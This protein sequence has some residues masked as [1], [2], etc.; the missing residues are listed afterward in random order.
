MI[1]GLYAVVPRPRRPAR[2]RAAR[3]PAH[4]RRSPPALRGGGVEVVHDA[5]FDTLT[6]RVPGRRRRRS[7]AAARARRHQP[8]RGRRRHARHRARRDDDAR[9]S[10]TR[11]SARSASTVGRRR[12]GGDARSRPRSRARRSSSRT[13]CSRRTA[14]RPDAAL[15]APA[16]RP[17]PRARPHDDPARLVHDEAQRDRRDGADHVARVRAHPPVRAGR[18]GRRATSS[19]STTSSAGSREITGY[20]AVSLQPN[21]GSQGEFAGLLAIREYHASQRRRRGA[22]CA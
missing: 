14:P 6:V 2:D 5:F 21:A 12:R 13:R 18:P 1:A 22:T 4:A 20:D 19:C 11:C 17:R 16:R 9:R 8:A 10:S 3:A 7:L 15:P